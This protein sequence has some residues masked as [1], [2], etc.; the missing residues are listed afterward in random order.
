MIEE[1]VKPWLTTNPVYAGKGLL[2]NEIYWRDNLK[3]LSQR[4]EQWKLA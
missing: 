2:T 3:T 1:P 4:W